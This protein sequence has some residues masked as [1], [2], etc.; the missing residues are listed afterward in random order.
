MHGKKQPVHFPK[1]LMLC[2]VVNSLRW[3]VSVCWLWERQK[4]YPNHLWYSCEDSLEW[5]WVHTGICSSHRLYPAV[6]PAVRSLL[7]YFFFF[8]LWSTKEKRCESTVL[9]QPISDERNDCCF[10]SGWVWENGRDIR[11]MAVID[12]SYSI[13]QSGLGPRS[14]LLLIRSGKSWVDVHLF[15]S[16]SLSNFHLSV[17][18]FLNLLTRPICADVIY[19][20]WRNVEQ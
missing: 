5:S 12:S 7:V 19:N 10:K 13:N 18:L 4:A 15:L 2:S 16:L 17:F 20:S 3:C 9:P 6:L 8:F 14:G 1:Y 11:A